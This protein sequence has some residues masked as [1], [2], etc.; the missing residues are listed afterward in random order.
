MPVVW[1]V[2]IDRFVGMT[3]HSVYPV[4]M[5][6]NAPCGPVLQHDFVPQRRVKTD[7]R[8]RDVMVLGIQVEVG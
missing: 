3:I 6:G 7:A 5:E 1:F 8:G 4:V 2:L